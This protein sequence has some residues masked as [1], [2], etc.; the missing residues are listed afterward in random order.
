MIQVVKVKL[1]DAVYHCFPGHDKNNKNCFN[2]VYEDA[3]LLKATQLKYDTMKK[4]Q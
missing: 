1:Q 2:I 3:E 4:I